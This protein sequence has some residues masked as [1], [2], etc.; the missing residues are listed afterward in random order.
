MYEILTNSGAKVVAQTTFFPEP[1]LDAGLKY[2][3]LLKENFNNSDLSAA[4]NFLN[5]KEL[6]NK[7]SKSSI[8]QRLPEQIT[9]FK[10][11]LNTAETKLDTDKQLAIA[12]APTAFSTL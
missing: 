10:Q 12:K 8:Q 7:H 2:I 1:Q 5:S 4:T 6:K 9:N 3:R 11:L